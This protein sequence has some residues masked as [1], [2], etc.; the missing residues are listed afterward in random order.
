MVTA[1]VT[2]AVLSMFRHSASCVADRFGP[3]AGYL[4]IQMQFKKSKLTL[5]WNDYFDVFAYNQ[6]DHP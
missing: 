2:H 4:G 3:L 5:L 1:L 6:R